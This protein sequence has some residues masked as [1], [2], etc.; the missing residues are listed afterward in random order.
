MA[1]SRGKAIELFGKGQVAKVMQM[2][3]QVSFV[4]CAL[5]TE[6]FYVC[7]K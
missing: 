4:F 7:R 2:F 1:E 3:W 5:G 6:L